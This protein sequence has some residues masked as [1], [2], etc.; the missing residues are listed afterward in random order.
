MAESRV[1][2][3]FGGGAVSVFG[4]TANRRHAVIDAMMAI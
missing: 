4:K 3:A 2:D 1:D